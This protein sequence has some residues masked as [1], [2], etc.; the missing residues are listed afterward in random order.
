MSLAEPARSPT[1]DSVD[2][3]ADTGRFDADARVTARCGNRSRGVRSASHWRTRTNLR[4]PPG[5]GPAPLVADRAVAPGPAPT[6]RGAA[7]PADQAGRGPGRLTAGR[8]PTRISP[9]PTPAAPG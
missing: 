6:R 7:V 9:T 1:V 5:P 4:D 3:Q 2:H 8:R